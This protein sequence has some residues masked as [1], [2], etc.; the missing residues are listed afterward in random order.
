MQI[1]SK[2]RNHNGLCILQRTPQN[3]PKFLSERRDARLGQSH[4][5]S[6]AHGLAKERISGMINKVTQINEGDDE[7]AFAE[8]QECTAQI[9]EI[10]REIASD[11][12]APS[13]AGCVLR[14]YVEKPAEDKKNLSGELHA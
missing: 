1:H 5:K 10:I 7:N 9:D 11:E 4:A 14:K 8:L 3:H 6:G 2:D 12:K 13:L